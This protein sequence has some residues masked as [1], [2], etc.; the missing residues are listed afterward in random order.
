MLMYVTS[1][2]SYWGL[3]NVPYHVHTPFQMA[4]YKPY[5]IA[6]YYKIS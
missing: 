3:I 4:Q 1:S 5:P 6:T 2:I